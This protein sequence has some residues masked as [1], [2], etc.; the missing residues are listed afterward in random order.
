MSAF[1]FLLGMGLSLAFAEDQ[2]RPVPPPSEST[3]APKSGAMHISARLTI[4]VQQP[5]ERIEEMI[6]LA[7]EM[8]GYYS[9]CSARDVHFKI[10]PSKVESF[11]AKL[12]ETGV[13]SEFDYS[14][15]AI[16][17]DLDNTRARIQARE[18]MIEQYMTVLKTARLEAIVMV[19]REV[20]NLISQIEKHKGKLRKLEHQAQYADI[21]VSLRFRD[22]RAPINNGSSPF[23][24]INRLNFDE[25]INNAQ[26][27]PIGRAKASPYPLPEGFSG[28][29]KGETNLAATADGLLYQSYPV[30]NKPEA[31]IDF[32][33]GAIQTRMT[34]AGYHPYTADGSLS[35]EQFGDAFVF[36]YSAPLGVDDYAYWIRIEQFGSKIW[37]TEIT[38][39]IGLFSSHEAQIDAALTSTD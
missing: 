36:R 34:D 38:G 12:K 8:G 9:S 5:E 19:E 28:F 6:A 30:K 4:N 21:N 15:K 17:S 35:G 25:L 11:L 27:E 16:E 29:K 32:W 37:I 20:L 10:P 13:L 26:Y 24:W 2:K 1:G 14:T 31:D 18:G 7:E 22:R 23:E 39:E 3:E 33:A